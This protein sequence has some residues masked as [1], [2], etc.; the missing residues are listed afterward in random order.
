MVKIKKFEDG[1]HSLNWRTFEGGAA[2]DEYL[3]VQPTHAE[4]LSDW[5]EQCCKLAKAELSKLEF[6]IEHPRFSPAVVI[7]EAKEKISV[8]VFAASILKDV[9]YCLPMLNENPA[10]AMRAAI[11]IKQNECALKIEINGAAKKARIR[12]RQESRSKAA[13]LKPVAARRSAVLNYLIGVGAP[14]NKESFIGSLQADWPIAGI[15]QERSKPTRTTLFSDLTEI[16]RQHPEY[17]INDVDV[18]AT[19]AS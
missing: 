18:A 6:D 13:K 16:Q 4:F 9:P 8:E 5:V 17:F 10:L 7:G 3:K 1:V 15:S 19:S 12:L 2:D 11:Q 14:N